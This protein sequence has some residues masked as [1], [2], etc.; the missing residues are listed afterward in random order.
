MEIWDDRVLRYILSPIGR[1]VKVDH[2]SEEVSKGLFARLRVKV[3]IS[4]H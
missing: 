1:L 3:D 2:K 4:N